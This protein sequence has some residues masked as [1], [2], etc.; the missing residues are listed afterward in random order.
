MLKQKSLPMSQAGNT[1]TS[2]CY[3][4]LATKIPPIALRIGYTDTDGEP[5]VLEVKDLR[6]KNADRAVEAASIDYFETTKLFSATTQLLENGTDHGGTYSGAFS[7]DNEGTLVCCGAMT[8]APTIDKSLLF[9]GTK[10]APA[11]GETFDQA[12]W[13]DL[14]GTTTTPDQPQAAAAEQTAEVASVTGGG[15]TETTEIYRW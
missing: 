11:D 14:V 8:F 10:Q 3:G 2:T 13:D 9:A 5:A 15:S 4:V 1:T 7:D 6:E 12:W